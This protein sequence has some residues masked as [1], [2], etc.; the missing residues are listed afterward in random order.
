M[1]MG[2]FLGMNVAL[3]LAAAECRNEPKLPGTVCTIVY[4]AALEYQSGRED[5]PLEPAPNADGN[6]SP[7]TEDFSP[8]A[9]HQKPPALLPLKQSGIGQVSGIVL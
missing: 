2:T 5:P 4:P 9:P 1:L 7:S 6:F 8:P 3:R